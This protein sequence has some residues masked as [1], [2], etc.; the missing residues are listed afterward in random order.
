MGET[1]QSYN[2]QKNNYSSRHISMDDDNIDVVNDNDK[3]SGEKPLHTV[4]AVSIC[5][6][7]SVES[8]ARS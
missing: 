5:S 2:H 1:I 8:P 4:V 3:D 7:N 6:G